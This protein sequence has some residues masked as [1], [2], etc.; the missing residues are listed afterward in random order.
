MAVAQGKLE[1]AARAYGDGL[2]IPK[3]LAAGDPSNTQWQRDLSV[4]Y[5][6]LGDVAVAQGKLEE[7]ARAYSDSL[8]IVKKLAAGDPS[9]TQWQRDL[10]VSYNKIGDVAVAQGK[11]EEAA[12][13]Y[14]DGLGIVKKLA[15][16]DP[17]NTDGSATWRCPTGGWPIW[18]SVRTKPA[19]LKATGSKHS[20]C[21]RAS[22]SRDL[23]L[24]PQDRQDLETL[25][26]KSG[27]AP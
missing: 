19:K 3:K 12:R 4:S 22:K 6:K 7:A 21:S 24:S 23:H 9:N 1:E 2:A 10:S 27:A 14:G 5:S 18:L 16:G 25:R 11:L 15:A 8:A 13:A 26:R 20:T 17:S